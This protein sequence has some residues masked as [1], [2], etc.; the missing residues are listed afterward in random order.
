MEILM[1]QNNGKKVAEI[2]SNNI[3]INKVQDALDL[4]ADIDYQGARNIIIHEKNLSPDFFNLRTGLAGD[5]LQKFVNYKVRLAIV[6]N[7]SKYDSNSLN[8]FIIECNRGSQFF[9]ADSIETAKGK[10][11]SI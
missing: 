1:H 4:M 11:L 7:F 6:G 8:A 3:L 10:L 2:I 5:I 9:F